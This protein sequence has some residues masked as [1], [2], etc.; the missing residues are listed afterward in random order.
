[1]NGPIIRAYIQY[2]LSFV[3]HSTGALALLEDLFQPP[4]TCLSWESC[5]RKRIFCFTSP[6]PPFPSLSSFDLAQ[7]FFRTS[8]VNILGQVMNWLLE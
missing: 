7:A 3:F 8:S 4:L 1:M 5:D 2:L 6:P